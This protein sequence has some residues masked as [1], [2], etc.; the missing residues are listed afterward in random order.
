[1]FSSAPMRRP[2]MQRRQQT[3]MHSSHRERHKHAEEEAQEWR[4]SHP[5]EL[6]SPEGAELFTLAH[7]QRATSSRCDARR[8]LGRGVDLGC[9]EE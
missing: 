4:E 1:M 6:I 8:G 5:P 9:P 3:N 2:D 7:G